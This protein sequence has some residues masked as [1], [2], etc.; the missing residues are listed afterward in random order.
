MQHEEVLLL[1]I[2][3]PLKSHAKMVSME[4]LSVSH[5]DISLISQEDGFDRLPWQSCPGTVGV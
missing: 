5:I 3:L 2:N 1:F 4:Y